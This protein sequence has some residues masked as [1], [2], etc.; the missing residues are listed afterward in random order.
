MKKIYTNILRF[1]PKK[2]KLI[3]KDIYYYFTGNFI[4]KT[5]K[6]SKEDYIQI[7]NIIKKKKYETIDN[8]INKKNLKNI[9]QNFLND[10]AFISQISI[11]KSEVNFQHGRLIYSILNDY[12]NNKKKELKDFV[13]IDVGTAKG[14]SSVLISKCG[15]DNKIRFKIFS[16]DI[17]PH[18]KKIYWNSIKD[19]DGKSTRKNLLK[20][21]SKYTKNINFIE[22]R[23]K[24]KFIEIEKYE[25]LNF[26]FLD[27]SHDYD[28]VKYEFDFIKKKQ[29]KGDIIFFD[30]VTEDHFDGIVRLIDEI[31]ISGEYKIERINSTQYR[32]Y[33]LATKQ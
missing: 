8:F 9:D 26:A 2:T 21:F 27:G 5:R 10:L 24:K 29:K 11:K 1:T 19:I 20:D 3:L 22:G 12:I 18:N 6:G 32:G 16:F 15:E 25:R 17:I 28:D 31:K 13:F 33:A 23:T 4:T 30:D 7:F 14:F